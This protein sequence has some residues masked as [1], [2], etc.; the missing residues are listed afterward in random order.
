MSDIF[1]KRNLTQEQMFQGIQKESRKEATVKFDQMGMEHLLQNMAEV[2]DT[3]SKMGAFMNNQFADSNVLLTF[4]EK[5]FETVSEYAQQ[6]AQAHKTIESDRIKKK[7]HSGKVSDQEKSANAR[8]QTVINYNQATANNILTTYNQKKQQYEAGE[9]ELVPEEIKLTGHEFELPPVNDMAGGLTDGIVNVMFKRDEIIE[10]HSR[11]ETKPSAYARARRQCEEKLLGY[12]EDVINT[13]FTANKVSQKEGKQVSQKEQEK[14]KQHLKL[15]MEKYEIA[16]RNLEADIS[17]AMMAKLQKSAPYKR[18]AEE[19]DRENTAETTQNENRMLTMMSQNA[20]KIGNRS[21]DIKKVYGNYERLNPQLN[22]IRKQIALID[23]QEVLGAVAK[24]EEE[25]AAAKKV[26]AAKKAELR[27]QEKA[28]KMASDA[29]KSYIEYVTMGIPMS[30]MDAAY[31]EK[32]YGIK[33]VGVQV[34]DNATQQ[35]FTMKMD[36]PVKDQE[37]GMTPEATK[38]LKNMAEKMDG[39]KKELERHTPEEIEA[40]PILKDMKINL[41]NYE[42]YRKATFGRSLDAYLYSN[43]N[44]CFHVVSE[45]QDKMQQRV[46]YRYLRQINAQGGRDMVTLSVPLEGEVPTEDEMVALTEDMSRVILNEEP[47][48]YPADAEH[49]NQIQQPTEEKLMDSY[50]R[51][52]EVLD[53]ARDEMFK[54]RDKYDVLNTKL[55]MTNDNPDYSVY[56]K[57]LEIPLMI[58]KKAQAMME[59]VLKMFQNEALI[60]RLTNEE[61]DDLLE[62]LIVGGAMNTL[63]NTFRRNAPWVYSATPREILDKKVPYF[64]T[65]PTFE[66]SYNLRK[67]RYTSEIKNW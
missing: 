51:V 13:Y 31:L 42:T 17:N 5:S 48:N 49:A 58:A 10:R 27:L 47:E 26:L 40:D 22:E 25:I 46:G 7:A 61:K 38:F 55:K 52:K 24:D 60:S 1:K 39:I 57:D 41:A 23:Q 53:K 14:A 43:E 56:F 19:K 18:L 44:Y 36:V 28:L 66:E 4:D 15:A 12:M 63:G 29:C 37:F 8:N 65:G 33:D 20:Q 50:K 64:S 11:K 35:E 59:A 45:F 6:H 9:L 16:A 67:Q 62:I 3:T 34:T 30:M 21:K 54:Y 2:E 32:E